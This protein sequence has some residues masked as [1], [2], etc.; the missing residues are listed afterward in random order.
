METLWLLFSPLNLLEF[1]GVAHTD[2]FLIR[3]SLRLEVRSD[4]ILLLV[5]SILFFSTPIFVLHMRFGTRDSVFQ[6]TG[7]R[8]YICSC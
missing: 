2:L 1:C 5:V 8:L 6:A 7:R 4:D 3:S